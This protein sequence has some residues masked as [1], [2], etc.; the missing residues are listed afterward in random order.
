M[1]QLDQATGTAL[2]LRIGSN[3]LSFARGDADS[4]RERTCAA[5][6]EL[7]GVD[8]EAVLSG[9]PRFF[10]VVNISDIATFKAS[11]PLYPQ[12]V[13][14]GLLAWRRSKGAEA[15]VPKL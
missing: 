9:N 6:A 13:A 3:V 11:F 2:A 5:L 8:V 1:Q 12:G 15:G 10:P 4:V 7:G 14:V